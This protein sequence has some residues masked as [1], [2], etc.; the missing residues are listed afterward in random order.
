MHSSARLHHRDIP[1][2]FG[3]HITTFPSTY[4]WST[5]SISPEMQVPSL[6]TIPPELLRI[7]FS[8]ACTDGGQTGCM[9]NLICKASRSVCLDTGVDIQSVFICSH[10]KMSSFLMMLSKRSVDRRK[11]VSLFLSCWEPVGPAQPRP[12]GKLV[13]TPFS[14]ATTQIRRVLRDF[15]LDYRPTSAECSRPDA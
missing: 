8:F 4:A 9:L 11:V 7:I 15:Q 3:Y 1:K 12:Q 2:A 13:D 5:H 10:T 6:S 14:Y